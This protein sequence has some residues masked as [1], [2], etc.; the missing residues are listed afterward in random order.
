M[1]VYVNTCIYFLSIYKYVI[2]LIMISIYQ[3]ILMQYADIQNAIWK[4]WICGTCKYIEHYANV[5][6]CD[7]RYAT[8]EC[9]ICV[10]CHVIMQ[11]TLMQM[12]ICE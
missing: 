3:Y 12:T 4:Y 8:C 2:T 10:I 9:I 11:I 6:V 7:M 1:S 5:R